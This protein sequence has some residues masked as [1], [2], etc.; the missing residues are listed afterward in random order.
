MGR[1]GTTD[2]VDKIHE[3]GM[4]IRKRRIFLQTGIYNSMP[5]YWGEM[6]DTDYVVRNLLFLDQSK[7]PIELWINSPGGSITEMWALYDVMRTC[8][9]DVITVGHGQSC[10]AACLLLAGGT[11][12]RYAMPNMSFMWHGGTE[13]VGA[14]NPQE[15]LDRAK[16]VERDR[17]RW[18]RTMARLTRPPKCRSLDA[19]TEWWMV[20][21]LAREEWL[22]ADEM[23][24]YGIV[25]E[26]WK[27]ENGD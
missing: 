13:G 14:V 7:G 9:N 20:R 3:Y 1:I 17:E 4:D 5:D 22:E 27:K 24:K 23:V 12:V 18:C 25:D 16:F 19:K 15:F 10:S 6:G 8:G 21:T 2:L 11:G 26:I